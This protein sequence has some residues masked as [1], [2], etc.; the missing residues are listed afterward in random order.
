MVREIENKKQLV[1]NQSEEYC[2][3]KG[4]WSFTWPVSQKKNNFFMVHFKHDSSYCL[5]AKPCPTFC[6][7]MNCSLPGSSVHGIS[8]ARILE[9]VAISSFRGS[10]QP[11]DRTHVSCIGRQIIYHWATREAFKH[12]YQLPNNW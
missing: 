8:Q 10:S 12:G 2:L 1:I 7:P 9:R 3:T 4:S 6:D 11:R 5:V